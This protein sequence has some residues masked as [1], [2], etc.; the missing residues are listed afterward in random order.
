MVHEGEY[1]KIPEVASMIGA[2]SQHTSRMLQDLLNYVK[3]QLY[4]SRIQNQKIYLRKLVESKLEL[5]QSAIIQK[6]IEVSD[7]IPPTTQVCSDYQLLSIVVHNIID[8]A[9]KYTN[10]GLVEFKIDE[11]ENGIELTISNS[12]STM[13]VEKMDFINLPY[14]NNKSVQSTTRGGEMGLL[15]IKEIAELIGIGIKVTQT[16]HVRFNLVFPHIASKAV[17]W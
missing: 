1:G 14:D 11:V 15:I 3:T 8:N 2:T 7:R 12:G 5:F 6:E 10:G 17:L 13:P 16:N 9:V 4:G